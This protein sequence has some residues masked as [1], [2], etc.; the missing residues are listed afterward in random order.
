MNLTNCVINLTEGMQYQHHQPHSIIVLC[1]PLQILI[2]VYPW[3][4]FTML[5]PLLK[6]S[7]CPLFLSIRV[8][9]VPN[10]GP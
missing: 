8:R 5:L 3:N 10:L 7:N 6:Y 1:R 9:Q 4:R 2:Q